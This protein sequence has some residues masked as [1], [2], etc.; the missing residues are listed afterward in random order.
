MPLQ[1]AFTESYAILE[2]RA[3]RTPISG[4]LKKTNSPYLRNKPSLSFAFHDGFGRHLFKV[5]QEL[6]EHTI[7]ISYFL[8]IPAFLIR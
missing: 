5:G 2:S 1:G 3:V 6:A 4:L 7:H 8:N